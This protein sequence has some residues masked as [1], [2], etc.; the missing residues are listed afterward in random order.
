[1]SRFPA[2]TARAAL[3]W[4]ALL[5]FMFFVN[6]TDRASLGPILV[7]IEQDWGLDH[8]Q[9]A[10]LLLF[11][12][13]GCSC[14]MFLSSFLA[15]RFK[16]RRIVA[17]SA[18]SGGIFLAAVQ[19]AGGYATAALAL[20]LYGLCAGLYF[21]AAMSAL[22]SLVTAS[23]WS[24]AVSIHELAPTLSFILT[25]RL[26][27][28]LAWAAGWRTAFLI[29]GLFTV[30][31][32]IMFWLLGRGGDQLIDVPSASGLRELAK[33]PMLWLLTWILALAAAGEFAPYSV[34][35]L[36]LTSDRGFTPASA[37][38]LLMQ[39]RLATPLAVLLGGW[40]A[41]RFGHARLLAFSFL[42]EALASFLMGLQWMPA[43]LTGMFIQPL[44]IAFAFPAIF[45]M[46]GLA[47]P[48]GLLPMA[49]AVAVPLGSYLG[50]GG[51]T[52]ILGYW[53]KL[54][55]FNAGFVMLGAFYLAT[56]L[57]T[58]HIFRKNPIAS[59]DPANTLKK[60]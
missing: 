20:T 34:L 9:S 57:V 45:S 58:L 11:M 36:H 14:G 59:I 38:T 32:G 3:P 26:A 21:N 22:T 54:L 1:M 24:W 28:G 53:G 43:F 31:S 19:F 29:L 30:A 13:T 23:L 2:G 5:A 44:A 16:P 42:L 27:D 15:S 4:V 40:T 7:Y 33:S 39:S 50:T 25:P 8:A 51:L 35:P 17:F 6:Y 47:F 60:T 56:T 10:R 37:G 49:L 52:A 46:F 48:A 55:S 12:S 41:S 18:I